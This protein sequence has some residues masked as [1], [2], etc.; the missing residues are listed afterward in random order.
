MIISLAIRGYARAVSVQP[1]ASA[2][3]PWFAGP[4]RI[5]RMISEDEHPNTRPRMATVFAASRAFRR[6]ELANADQREGVRRAYPVEIAQDMAKP[7]SR[8]LK[9]NGGVADGI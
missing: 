7:I 2:R 3:W 4:A 9:S 6:A 5:S 1:T 8:N